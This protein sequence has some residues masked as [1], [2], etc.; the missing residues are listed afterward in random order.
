MGSLEYKFDN[1]G[2]IIY[3]N[4]L[5]NGASNEEYLNARVCVKA[6]DLSD[7]QAFDDLNRKQLEMLA[8]QKLANITA[9]KE[10]TTAAEE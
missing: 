3:V 5:F 8:R 1:T 10:D 7:G 2:N 6:E 9:V 4:C